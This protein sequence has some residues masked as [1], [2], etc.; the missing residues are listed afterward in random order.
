MM[1]RNVL[2]FRTSSASA[3][4]LLSRKIN[5]RDQPLAFREIFWHVSCIN[6]K[7]YAVKIHVQFT[8]LSRKEPAFMNIQ[9]KPTGRRSFLKKSMT[10]LVGAA[11]LPS[12]LK[13]KE[14]NVLTQTGK[15]RKFICRSLGKT[16]LKLPV[17]SIG[18]GCYEPTVYKKALDEGIA[19]IDT[20][21]YYYNGRHE[22]IVADAIKDR[23]RDSFVIATS[24]LLGKG[25]PG[26]FSTMRKE[27]APQLVDRFDIS[28][29]RLGLDT[30]D[31]FYVAGTDSRETALYEP[32]MSGL[33]RIKKQGKARFV[34]VAAHQDEPEVLR[35]AVESN[36][37]DVVLVAYNFRHPRRDEIK[38]AMAEAAKAGLGIIVMK[39]M[40][41]AFWDREKKSPINGKAALKWVLQDENVTTSVPGISSLD[42]LEAD[43][44]VMESLALTPEEKADLKLA[45][46]SAPSGLYCPQCGSCQT[47]CPAGLE[48]PLLMRSYMYAYGYRDLG[49]AR[50]ALSQADMSRLQCI[51][52]A[53]CRVSCTMGF[54]VRERALDIAKLNSEIDALLL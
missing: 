42:Q 12:L 39:P 35:A 28:L 20:S 17:V 14:R 26:S 1:G 23:P 44:S 37:H 50:A 54:D 27:D 49:K 25:T 16:G 24:I 51:D 47:Q 13:S 19:H 22:Q 30:V 3:N 52:C 11:F 7:Q 10:S 40:A 5:L 9:D 29:K 6:K 41:G 2:N 8:T 32:L 48:I 53:T 33:Q 4:L 18:A 15:K 45:D 36:V 21:Q 46:A 34:G 31:I 43:L 38:T